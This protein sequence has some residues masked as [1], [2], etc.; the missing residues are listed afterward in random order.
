VMPVRDEWAAG[1]AF[2]VAMLLFVG[3]L[4]LWS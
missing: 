3:F 1:V 4:Y 2:I